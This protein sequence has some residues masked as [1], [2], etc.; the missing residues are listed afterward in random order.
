MRR[1]FVPLIAL[2]VVA[3]VAS[4]VRP[5]AAVVPPT[6]IVGSGTVYG[7][8]YPN[9]YYFSGDFDAIAAWTGKHNTFAGNFHSIYES[10]DWADTWIKLEEAWKA[11][12]TPFANLGFAEDAAT[13][14]SGALDAQIASWATAVKS[15][16]DLGEGRSLIIGPMP[17]MNGDWIPYGMEPDDFKIGY[18]KIR[19]IV[20][21]TV[22]D[23]AKVRWAFV[24]NGWS[25]PPY[26]IAD[27][28]PGDGIVDVIGLSTYNFGV[29]DSYNAP[30]VEPA[31]AI[32]PYV[33]EVRATIPGSVNKPF[34]LA[35]TGSVT[36]TGD[37]NKWISD[38]FAL[39]DED[40]NLVGFIYFNINPAGTPHDW[41]IWQGGASLPGFQGY[42]DGMAR[43][44]TKYQFPLDNWFQPGP[45]PFVQYGSPCPDGADC[46][47]IALTDP[48]FQI[49]LYDELRQTSAVNEFYYGAPGDVPLMGDWDGDGID[50]PGIYRPSDGFVRLRNSNTTGV[51]DVTFWY[52]I[53][54]DIPIAGDWNSD[55]IDTLG[56]YRGGQVFLR[57]TLDTGPADHDFWFGDPGDRPFTG[58]FDGDGIDTL[59][60]YRE[61]SGL[62]YFRNTLDTGVADFEFFYGNPSDRILAGDWNG[63]DSDTVAV[64]RPADNKVYF[65]MTNTL[66]V[67]DFT[68][69]VAPGFIAAMAARV[70]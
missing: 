34:L 15:W 44:T 31:D 51:A 28:Y 50:T 52:G 48:G 38:M 8:L 55:G 63:D 57:D 64:Y 18:A 1:I 7:G 59:G 26:G 54:G 20:E 58:D 16:L 70:H 6:P 32:Q 47:S 41:V 37:K 24:P 21:A 5:A 10:D 29:H 9:S 56:V 65:R 19:S 46:D 2:V 13:V 36:A 42:L 40:P 4:A 33:D 49:T 25:T 3:S 61:T 66:G 45:L 62:V 22:A 43:A 53:P 60:L 35:Q 12:A 14:A 68:L 27:Y 23:P 11:G 30:W 67:A 17:E 39:I 69:P